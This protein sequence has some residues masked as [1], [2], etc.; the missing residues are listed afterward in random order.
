M[1]DFDYL[2][3]D[4]RGVERSG[5]VIAPSLDEARARLDSR[6]LYVVR[7]EPGS[8][9]PKASKPRSRRLKTRIG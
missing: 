8:G 4:T 5:S 3:I 1:P 7:I 2:A 6:K 9:A